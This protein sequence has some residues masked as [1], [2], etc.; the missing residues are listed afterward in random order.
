MIRTWTIAG[1]IAS[2]ALFGCGS[3]GSTGE[4]G[5]QGP[6]GPE[7]PQ[8]PEGPAGD[9][10]YIASAAPGWGSAFSQVTLTGENFSA[11]A[12]DNLVTFDGFA[13]TVVSASETDL[14]VEPGVA[15]DT[16]EFV[17]INVEVG[18]QVSNSFLFELVPSGHARALHDA[19]PGFFT[20]VEAVGGTVYFAAG[21]GILPT[22]GLYAMDGE[23]VV[24]KVIAATPA[25]AG[26][27][28][29]FDGPL[30]LTRDGGNLYYT[31]VRGAVYRYDIETGSSVQ[32]A[33]PAVVPADASDTAQA[34]D[35]VVDGDDIFVLH[36][37]DDLIYVYSGDA[38][39]TIAVDATASGLAG[40]STNLYYSET[41]TDTVIRIADP[42][43]TPVTTASFVTG[44]SNP[45]GLAVVGADLIIADSNG[46][47]SA[48]VATGGAVSVVASDS[49]N[50][51]SGSGGDL[52]ATRAG[53]VSQLVTVPDGDTETTVV[54]GGH[55]ILNLGTEPSPNGYY[56][57]QYAGPGLSHLLELRLDGSSRLVHAGIEYVLDFAVADDGAIIAAGYQDQSIWSIDP[58]TGEATLVADAS[59]GL[60]Q[61]SSI[62][63]TSN[64]TIF[65]IDT[66]D[67]SIGRI[68]ATGTVTPGFGDLTGFNV[69]GLNLVGTDDTL[70][71]STM[72]TFD[73]PLTPEVVAISTSTGSVTSL[74]PPGKAGNV[75]GLGFANGELMIGRLGGEILQVDTAT[76]EL[77][78][79]GQLP[80]SACS[81]LVGLTLP[82]SI[83]GTAS[84]AILVNSYA[85]GVA[86]GLAP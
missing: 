7:G 3:D 86:V 23:G 10:P 85:C 24:R 54:Y 70:Y 76:G 40:D 47:Q 69:S 38:V 27:D 37:G 77:I 34:L 49:V 18:E 22:G 65:Y 57:A 31:S 39:D 79:R 72:Q 41:A 14:V 45:A 4:D 82:L 33:A 1:C 59:D 53:F 15:T 13:A 46:I 83:S 78:P 36:G 19:L 58:D 63:V 73:S 51:I 30:A 81:E 66:D 64:G 17:S 16:P 29:Y 6:A 61:P 32:I 68:S 43:G 60:L 25:T 75:S 44:L 26:T 2:A 50:D 35:L 71:A 5:E 8:G 20:S 12:E 55:Q 84:G 80:A 28:S 56:V 42:T 48:P 62:H 21:A 11:T 52:F 9:A 67:A 74:V